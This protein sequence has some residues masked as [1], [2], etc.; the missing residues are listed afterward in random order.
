[1]LVVSSMSLS[2]RITGPQSIERLDPLVTQVLV[3]AIRADEVD[4]TAP[5]VSAE[6]AVQRPLDFVWETAC[7]QTWRARHSE[8]RILNRLHNTIIIEDKSN[9]AFLQ[10]RMDCPVL[11]TYVACSP[12][13]V[14]VWAEMRWIA[15]SNNRVFGSIESPSEAAAAAAAAT[16]TASAAA[17]HDWWAVKS[18]KGNG[19]RDVWMMHK[20]NYPSVLAELPT[21]EELVI[22]R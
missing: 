11:E 4:K 5:S 22:Q 10:L 18:S 12:S 15:P 19:G 7:E 21:G 17:V 3:G 6:E 1:M 2:Y 13:D 14:K 16:V 9:L 20:D 8:A